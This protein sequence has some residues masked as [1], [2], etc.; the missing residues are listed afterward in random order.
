MLAVTVAIVLIPTAAYA[1]IGRL[2]FGRRY[3]RG[4]GHEL[5]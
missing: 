1:A 4:D 5:L 3:S 2:Q